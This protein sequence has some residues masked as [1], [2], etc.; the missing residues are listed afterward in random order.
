MNAYKSE[1]YTFAKLP[2]V[3]LVSALCV[4]LAG[5]GAS[6]QWSLPYLL[7]ID[8]PKSTDGPAGEQVAALIA[9]ADPA[10]ERF[11]LA[12]LDI[13]GS[14]QS[15]GISSFLMA[16]VALGITVAI[17]PFSSGAIVWKVAKRSRSPWAVGQL[18]AILTVV[19]LVLVAACVV[20][21]LVALVATEILHVDLILTSELPLVWLRG[22]AAMLLIAT[23]IYGVVLALRKSGPA[24]GVII[25][26]VM[27]GVILG[28]IGS[29]AGWDPALFAWLPTNAVGAAG[30]MGLM[31]SISPALGLLCLT[32]WAAFSLSIGLLRFSRAN[33]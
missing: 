19:L 1:L 12:A 7:K 16:I 13:T 8:P 24:V 6:L 18:L 11:Q 30:G 33:L 28:T 22:A 5:F 4:L 3:R 32:G 31:E 17:V 15:S 21:L 10:L 26:I 2:T 9:A 29:M 20:S 25:A 27:L 14:G 23:A